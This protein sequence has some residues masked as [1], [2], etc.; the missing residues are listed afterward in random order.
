MRL[1]FAIF[2]P[3]DWQGAIERFA[4]RWQRAHPMPSGKRSLRW[5]PAERTHLTLRFLGDCDEETAELLEERARV[6]FADSSAFELE[7]TELGAFPSPEKARVL[8]MGVGGGSERLCEL[9]RLAEG[10]ALD[11][12][13]AAEERTFHPH[14]TLARVRQGS[15]DLTAQMLGHSL[16]EGAM[17]APSF[18]VEGVELV[19]STLSSTGP[20]YSSRCRFPL[21]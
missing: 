3:A 1:F 9:A 12:G 14:L 16:S 2:P 11:A 20:A 8:W 18:T 7:L 13:F 15:Q 6:A 19:A 5:T 17:P 10:V 21:R 4:G